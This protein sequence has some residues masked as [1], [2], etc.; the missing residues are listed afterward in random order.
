MNRPLY[1]FNK[2]IITLICISGIIVSIQ[3][4]KPNGH[5]K[6][7]H[8]TQTEPMPRLN[9]KLDGEK[10]GIGENGSYKVSNLRDS[11]VN[12][13]F[14]VNQWVHSCCISS[15]QACASP[16]WSTREASYSSLLKSAVAF[17]VADRCSH[18]ET[19]K[20]ISSQIY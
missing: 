6:I 10:N 14:F 3:P 16:L 1:P 9:Q 11:P 15:L 5:M 2:E 18:C 19:H 20:L 13:C 4:N 7:S 8:K 17:L 12:F